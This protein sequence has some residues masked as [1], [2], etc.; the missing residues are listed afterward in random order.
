MPTVGGALVTPFVAFGAD[1]TPAPALTSFTVT[2]LKP[3]NVT[4]VGSVVVTEVG[5]GLYSAAKAATTFDV[6][7]AWTMRVTHATAQTVF[8]VI[9]VS[10]AA[11]GPATDPLSNP[12]PGSYGVGTA[13]YQLG[14]IGSAG[15]TVVSPMAASGAV[16]LYQNATYS[17]ARGTA[18]VW[19]LTSALV[20]TGGSVTLDSGGVSYAGAITG[21]AGAWV[22]TVQLTAAQT[23][24]MALGVKRYDLSATVS[25]DALPPL[26]VG[27]LTVLKNV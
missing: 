24:A 14:R 5:G 3:D 27:T 9:D 16:T 2:L 23:A 20:L 4:A 10:A 18:L 1:G 21:A 25:G 11:S 26:A 17:T 15:A 7:G 8:V 6:A 12:V 19:S 22:V 13:G